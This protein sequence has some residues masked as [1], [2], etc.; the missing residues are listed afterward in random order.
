M[1]S[2]NINLPKDPLTNISI[3]ELGNKFRNGLVS[4]KEITSIYYERIKILNPYLDAY[5]H[6]DTNQGLTWA[7]G[8]DKLFS[9]GVDLGP[10]MGIPV[11]IK[12]ICSVNEMPTTNGSLISSDDITGK[13]GK[14][15]K[16]LKSLGCVIL[17]K[18]H[19][20]EF[21]L[22]ATG[23]NKYKGT[24]KNPWDENIHRMPGGS[25][26]GSAVAVASG[27]AA[28]AIGTDTGGSVRIPASLN[29]VVGLK[30]TKNRWP[31]DGIFPLSPT[32]DTPGPIARNVK[33]IKLI[34]NTYNGTTI[35]QKPIKLNG[36]TFGK[37]KE[38]FTSNLD[39]EVEEAYEIICNKLE[40]LGANIEEVM[41]EANEKATLFPAIV[42][43]E[44]ISAFGK[45]RFI[46]N[47][48]KMD[49]VTGNRAKLG[50]NVS[51]F[52][53]IEAI[54]RH[55]ELVHIASRYFSKYDALISPT[56][57]MQA[58]EVDKSTIGGELHER[59]LLASANTQP[60]NILGLCG[61]S[62]PI[63]NLL[64]N[65]NSKT[66]PIGLQIVCGKN[67]DEKAVEI[68]LALENYLGEPQLPDVSKFL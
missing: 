58:L 19:T 34:F 42:G 35:D 66:L 61:I 31:T 13:E 21:A 43:S 17:G 63:H 59:S 8:M 52:Q 33:D 53:Y 26:S 4:C 37:L 46:K 49:P 68:A 38:P 12:D 1:K 41:T 54:N 6:T 5:I 56:T 57:V 55:L 32:L 25:S 22:G 27:L 62:F 51:S 40:K 65:K 16:R 29:G 48:E 47:V 60:V 30:T 23:L 45:D 3:R 15:I 24:P 67:E 2:A 44:I 64:N 9:C 39:P 28:F 10:L 14:L 18:T 20:V 11:A 7:D 36:M 50:L